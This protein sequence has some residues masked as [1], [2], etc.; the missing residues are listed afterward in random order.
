MATGCRPKPSGEYA[1]R[2]GTETTY[3]FGDEEAKL[4]EYVW[5]ERNSNNQTHAVGHKEAEWLG[6]A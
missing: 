6:S 2:A 1:C 3:S 5:F 4:G